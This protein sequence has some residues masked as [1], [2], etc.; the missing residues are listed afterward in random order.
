[1]KKIFEIVKSFLVPV[2]VFLI[3]KNIFGTVV[4]IN[5]WEQISGVVLTVG[6]LFASFWD[7][8]ATVE[9]I[10]TG[11]SIVVKSSISL[12]FAFGV[13][14]SQADVELWLP[15]IA[16]VSQ[17][18]Y[19]WFSKKKTEQIDNGKLTTENGKVVANKYFEPGT[20]IN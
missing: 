4:D 19:R 18:I 2:G 20:G 3:G 10:Q 5:I 8:T 15:L 1:M 6:G 13:L 7:R 17:Q 14:K 9:I 11:L 12:L 16:L